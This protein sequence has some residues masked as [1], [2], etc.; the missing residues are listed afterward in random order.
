MVEKVKLHLRGPKGD[1]RFSAAST[2]LASTMLKYYCNKVGVEPSEAGKYRLEFDG[3][4]FEAEASVEDMGLESGDLI[5][6]SYR[7]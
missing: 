3:E 4:H 5:D 1:V 6:V 7:A 2:T